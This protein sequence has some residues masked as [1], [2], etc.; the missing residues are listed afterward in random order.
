MTTETAELDSTAVGLA[1]AYFLTGVV[2]LLGIVARL[3]GGERW[4]GLLGDVYPGYDT[5]LR[6]LLAGGVRAFLHGLA[7]GYAI[8]WLYNR[9]RR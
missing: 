7:G 2:V 6:G 3:G 8:A 5:S 1:F 4:R 9:F